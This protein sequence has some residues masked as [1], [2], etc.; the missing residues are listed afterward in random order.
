MKKIFIIT[1][2]LSL[3]ITLPATAQLG[4]VW[5]DFQSYSADLQNHLRNNLNELNPLQ[6]QSQSAITGATGE[7][8]IPNPLGAGEILSNDINI[9]L[10]SSNYETNPL[11]NSRVFGNEMNRLIFRS[12]AAGT[13]GNNGQLRT[14]IKLQNIERELK[15]IDAF[16]EEADKINQ[17]F[18]SEAQNQVSQLTQISSNNPLIGTLLNA[19]NQ[20][21]LTL[22]Q[23]RIQRDQSKIIAE[24]LA[25]TIHENQL[26]QYSNLNLASIGEQIEDTNR[27][28]RV[29][30]STE[31]AR[32][33]RTTSQ[34]DLFGR[35]P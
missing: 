27:A 3:I 31:A 21:N 11:I 32:L 9:N 19:I 25:Q 26:L 34:T 1:S 15:N 35:K 18:V 7:L 30:N 22:Q 23:I 28:R 6:I 10:L 29:D 24:T 4:Q 12:S 20:S 8:N 33:L 5:T 14:K 17:D 13:L 16:S 2:F